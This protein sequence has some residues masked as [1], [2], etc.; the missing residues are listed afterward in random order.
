[1]KFHKKEIKEE[2]SNVLKIILQGISAFTENPINSRLIAPSGEGKTYLVNKV[3]ATF[4]EQSLII[5]SSASAQSF[6]Y[7][8]GREVIEEENGDFTPTWEKIIPLE[9]ALENAKGKEK[10]DI[11]KQ[12]AQLHKESWYL[13]DFRNKWLIFWILRTCHY[14]NH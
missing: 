6:K 8:H 2:D 12:I 14:G 4:P 10:R 5:L 13:I 1:M 9:E 11:E 3:S 7:S